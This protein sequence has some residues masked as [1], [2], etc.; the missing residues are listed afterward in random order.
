MLY[1][2]RHIDINYVEFTHYRPQ[3]IHFNISLTKFFKYQFPPTVTHI[4]L[5]KNRELPQVIPNK[6]HHISG[7]EWIDC[8]FLPSTLS[9]LLLPSEFADVVRFPNLKKLSLHPKFRTLTKN[10]VRNIPASITHLTTSCGLNYTLP[11]NLTHLTLAGSDEPINNLPDSLTNLTLIGSKFTKSVDLPKRLRYLELGNKALNSIDILPDTITHLVLVEAFS[12]NLIQFPSCLKVLS[13]F[14]HFNFPA[15]ILPPTLKTLHIRTDD[16]SKLVKYLPGFTDHLPVHLNKLI[17]DSYFNKPLNNLP[18]NLTHL[19]LRAGFNQP[20]CC[21]PQTLK[22][23][24]LWNPEFNQ[25]VDGL[26]ST[27]TQLIL[28]ND[29]Y[30]HSLAKLPQH[31]DLFV[32]HQFTDKLDTLPQSLTKLFLVGQFNQPLKNLPKSLTHFGI[33]DDFEHDIKGKLPASV[34]TLLY[35]D[36]T[37]NFI[38]YMPTIGV[39]QIGVRCDI[40]FDDLLPKNI[41]SKFRL[42]YPNGITLFTFGMFA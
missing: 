22:T 25:P 18:K 35:C 8:S 33:G 13:I 21:L 42:H 29:H 12:G 4:K 5:G 10:M 28:W 1:F 3:K 32:T 23:L 41:E 27:L 15:T 14:H 40:D 9:E 31:L 37:P 2:F 7:R 36:A 16:A 34:T 24:I 38:D 30:S 39:T 19:E 11:P 6:L 26:P 20:I 17:I